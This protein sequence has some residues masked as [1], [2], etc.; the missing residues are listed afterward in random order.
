MKD[1]GIEWIGEIPKHWGVCHFWNIASIYN[2]NSIKDDEKA[3]L[4]V[5]TLVSSAG[6]TENNIQY[7][8]WTYSEKRGAG[9]MQFFTTNTTTGA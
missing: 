3:H 6:R 5:V 1:S 7:T 8:K 9:T 4:N 2:G